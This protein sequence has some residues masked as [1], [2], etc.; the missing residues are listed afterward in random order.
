M[1]TFTV[2]VY[3]DRSM[4]ML[5][6]TSGYR[7]KDTWLARLAADDRGN[8]FMLVTALISTMAILGTTV[9]TM[10]FFEHKEVIHQLHRTQ[11]LYLPTHQLLR[12]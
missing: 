4:K 1:S 10:T 9:S 7:K 12:V 8:T 5:G 11:A 3:D 2:E 6:I